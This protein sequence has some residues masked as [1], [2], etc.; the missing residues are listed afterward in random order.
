MIVKIWAND[1]VWKKAKGEEIKIGTA[2]AQQSR[3]NM[4][5]TNT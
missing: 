3:I 1:A 2:V 5:Q 4:K